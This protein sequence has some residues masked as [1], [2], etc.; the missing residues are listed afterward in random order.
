MSNS[1]LLAQALNNPINVDRDDSPTEVEYLNDPSSKSDIMGMALST[2]KVMVPL[3][4]AYDFLAQQ[5][6]ILIANP[7][8]QVSEISG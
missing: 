7:N 3:S 6:A 1:P 4:W 2:A 5:W 8:M